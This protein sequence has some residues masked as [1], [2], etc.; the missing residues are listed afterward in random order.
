MALVTGSSRGLGAAVARRLARDGYTVAVNGLHGDGRLA[1]VVAA[2]W[3]EGGTAEGFAADVTDREQAE[4]LVAAVSATLGVVGALV[5]NA[6]GPQP[7]APLED[8][9]WRDHLDQ[10][11]FF[12][13]SPVLLGQAVLP[14]MRERRFGR[15]VHIDSEIA[16]RPPAGRSAYATAKN[17]QIGLMRSWANE[18]AGY[19]ITVNTV[20]PGFIPVERHADVDDATRSAYLATVPVG[21]MGTPDDVA[22]AVS[23]LA[24]PEAG[25]ITG[26]RI[27][28]DGGRS[29]HI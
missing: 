23:V 25:F 8:V 11:D 28:V 14:G 1:E 16:D 5:L 9:A 10:L 2:I 19:G 7:E 24:S 18:L 4:E 12:V 3:D 13:R 26:Q 22:Y 20:A 15:I 21:R 6:T 27:L 29:L 17:A